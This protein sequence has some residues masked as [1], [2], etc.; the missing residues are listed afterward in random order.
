MFKENLDIT[1]HVKTAS[2]KS[3]SFNFPQYFLLTAAV[4]FQYGCNL[5]PFFSVEYWISQAIHMGI[6]PQVCQ[7]SN[8][9]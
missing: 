3:Y 2:E 8:I 1:Y 5:F 6:F 7:G 9:A 4:T